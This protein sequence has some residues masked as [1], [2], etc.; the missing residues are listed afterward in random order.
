MTIREIFEQNWNR[1]GRTRTDEELERERW[2]LPG[3]KIA[4]FN[5]FALFPAC[6]LIQVQY[7][8]FF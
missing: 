1:P 4:R 6:F 8:V 5:R 3:V 7:E 2:L